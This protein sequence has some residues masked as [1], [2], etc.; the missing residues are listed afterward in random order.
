MKI[1]SWNVNGIRAALRKDFLKS[2]QEHNPDIICLQETKAHP[3][4]VE[5]ELKEYEHHY[6]NSAERKGYSGTAIFSKIKPLSV[7]YGIGNP[8]D[9]E[10]RVITLEF[11]DYYLVTVY[12]PNAKMD[13]SRLDFRYNEWDKDFLK[14]VNDLPKPTIFCGDLNI[15]HQEIDLKNSAG[16]KTTKIKPGSCGF[17][18]KERESFDNIVDA[19]Y[20]D[21]FRHFN[22]EE[23]K[24]S[25]WSYMFKSRERNAGWRLDYFCVN[26]TLKDRMKSADILTEVHGSDHCPVV[27]ELE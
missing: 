7:K 21:S 8:A 4:Q 11:E 3:E 12:T 22:P 1:L 20:I 2:M 10:G 24:Y 25:W 18:D 27:L 16:N 23:E 17:T 15:A 13:L 6:W 14:Y 19:G 26:N 9:I 5:M